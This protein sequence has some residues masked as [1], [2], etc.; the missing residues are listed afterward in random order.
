MAREVGI[1]NIMLFPLTKDAEGDD[2]LGVQGTEY[3]GQSTLS[4]K[5]NTQK[6]NTTQTI[7]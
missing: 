4:L 6:E 7:L 3:L 2:Q 5:M 1:S